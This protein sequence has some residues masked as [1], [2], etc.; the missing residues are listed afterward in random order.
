MANEYSQLWQSTFARTIP[1]EQTDREVAFLERWL[2]RGDVLDV[3][4]GFGRHA[5]RL[6]AH[7]YRVVGL[8]RDPRVAA[9]AAREGLEVVQADMRDL[10]TAVRGDFDGIVSM[11]SS[12]GFYDDETNEA[13]LAAMRAKLRD[14]GR[15]VVDTWTPGFHRARQGEHVLERAGRRVR[16]TKRVVG[17]RMLIALDYGAGAVDEL[18]FRLYHPEE[19]AGELEL[20]VAC[21]RFDED[22]PPR[23]DEPRMQLVFGRR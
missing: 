2:P 17:D 5:L 3:C 21:C 16:E 15:L 4:C 9:A 18:D 10:A 12:L 1:G 11:W 7:G 8:E 22:E 13:V 14:G 6:Q 19:L 23:D 20:L